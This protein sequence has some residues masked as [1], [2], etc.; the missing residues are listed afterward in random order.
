M[1]QTIQI[2]ASTIIGGKKYATKDRPNWAIRC[3]YNTAVFHDDR[4]RLTL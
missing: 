3:L 4:W 2:L 1:Y